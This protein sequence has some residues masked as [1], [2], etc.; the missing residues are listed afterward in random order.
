MRSSVLSKDKMKG[1]LCAVDSLV[2]GEPMYGTAAEADAWILIEYRG[3][4]SGDA[5]K[6]SG[7]QKAA[8]EKLKKISKSVKGARLQVVSQNG[9]DGE[10]ISLFIARSSDTDA[11]LYEINLRSY[12]DL[13]SLDIDSV[14]KG[15]EYER[16]EPLVIVCTNGERDVCCGKFGKPVYL[17]AAA[18]PHGR[19]VWQT[20]HIGGHRF[21]ATFVCLPHGICYGRVREGKVVDEVVDK[22][23]R[24]EIDLASLRG[25]SSYSSEAQAAEYFLRTETG[26]TG[27]SEFILQREKK[28]K[29]GIAVDFVSTSTGEAH[30]VNVLKSKHSVKVLKD[31]GD[32]KRSGV[33]G[34]IY[35]GHSMIET[36]AKKK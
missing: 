16:K 26:K 23:V 31:C 18:G 3:R 6:D 17:E 19:N 35:G 33:S 27:I 21:A 12:D 20:N 4:W 32:S 14:L 34:F 28:T 15:D 24:G 22:Y 1:T 13:L 10:G 29:D 25:R 2:G 8:K 30:R 7:I 36:G 9:R 5:Y 11:K